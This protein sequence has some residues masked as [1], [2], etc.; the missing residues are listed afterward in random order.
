MQLCDKLLI[1]LTRSKA[2]VPR[3]PLFAFK[4]SSETDQPSNASPPTTMIINSASLAKVETPPSPAVDRFAKENDVADDSDSDSDDSDSDYLSFDDDESD[5]EEALAREKERQ[6]VLEAAGLIVK[7][8]D[9][10]PPPRPKAR[11][12]A[13]A[14][15]RRAPS[16]NTLDSVNKELPAPPPMVDDPEPEPEP[17]PEPV[18]HEARL[19]DAF[20]RYESFKNHQLDLNRLSIVSTAT[21]ASEATTVPSSPTGTFA[22]SM[23][24]VSLPPSHAGRESDTSSRYSGFLGRLTGATGG[25]GSPGERE[26]RS[27]AGLSI[28]APMMMQSSSGGSLAQPTPQEPSRAN[29]PSFGTVCL[30]LP[31]LFI[32]ACFLMIDHSRGRVWLTRVPWKVYLLAKERG[33]K[34]SLSSLQLKVLMLETFNSLSR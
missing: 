10:P 1:P 30:F 28:S 31:V 17:E 4:N 8:N 20:A 15:P 27:V 24:S 13:P 11:R 7:K 32:E 22:S 21:V 2:E 29:S 9:G 26:R 34:P 6:L 33:K 23:T 19:D 14:A 12:P 16:V 18:S 3:G 5:S 25:R